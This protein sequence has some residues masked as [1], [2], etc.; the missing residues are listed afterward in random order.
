MRVGCSVALMDVMS[1][2]SWGVMMAA[3]L[4][5]CLVVCW[6]T[7]SVDTLVD[8]LDESLVAVKVVS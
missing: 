7:Y 2:V 8:D 5:V 1:E 4:V 6:D 3:Y